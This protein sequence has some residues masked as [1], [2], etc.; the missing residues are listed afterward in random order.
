MLLLLFVAVL[1][2]TLVLLIRAV[3]RK[4]VMGVVGGPEPQP[5]RFD[6]AFGWD[7]TRL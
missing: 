7:A 3:D 1:V 4:L 5:H 2:F 6:P